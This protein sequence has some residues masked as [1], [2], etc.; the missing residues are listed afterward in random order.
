MSTK[1]NVRS[2]REKEIGAGETETHHEQLEASSDTGSAGNRVE[3]ET[4]CK[5]NGA[6]KEVE[7]EMY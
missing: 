6:R 5:G 1:S 4:M 7:D 2:S 3:T